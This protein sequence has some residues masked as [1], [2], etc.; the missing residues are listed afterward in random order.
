[1]TAPS[2]CVN[3]DDDDDDDDDDGTTLRAS[4]DIVPWSYC[5]MRVV[6][7]CGWV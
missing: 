1:M 4:L 7:L 6:V 3:D 2:Y 5:P